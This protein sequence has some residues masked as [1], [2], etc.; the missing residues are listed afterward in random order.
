MVTSEETPPRS[1]RPLNQSELTRLMQSESTWV[2]DYAPKAPIR[3]PSEETDPLWRD[4]DF[5]MSEAR[6]AN[7]PNVSPKWIRPLFRKPTRVRRLLIH[8][9]TII[10]EGLRERDQRL[11]RLEAEVA[12]LSAELRELRADLHREASPAPGQTTDEEPS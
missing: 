11:Q 1:G 8:I 2:P 9:I 4:V 5:N 12:N 3:K 7:H 6:A 10:S